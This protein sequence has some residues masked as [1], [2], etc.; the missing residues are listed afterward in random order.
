VNPLN[1]ENIVFVPNSSTVA[2]LCRRPGKSCRANELNRQQWNC[3]AITHPAGS[4]RG[5]QCVRRNIFAGLLMIRHA[6]FERGQ[7]RRFAHNV[8]S[9]KLLNLFS[10]QTQ[11]ILL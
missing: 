4:R 7:G 2:Q 6:G 10:R 11:T 3:G 9:M 1:P 5:K 8:S